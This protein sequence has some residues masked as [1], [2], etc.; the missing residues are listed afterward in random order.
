[1]DER[2]LLVSAPSLGRIFAADG[3]SHFGEWLEV[4]EAGDVVFFREAGSVHLFVL[5][6]ATF[7]VIGDAGVEYAG[8]AGGDVDV[9]DGHCEIFA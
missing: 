9:T 4:N 8:R 3:V 5:G 1:M 7:E 6:H 2:E